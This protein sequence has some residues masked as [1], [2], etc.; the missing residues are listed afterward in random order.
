MT[1]NAS[2]PISLAGTTAGQS[3][4]IEL[5]GSGT[6]QACAGLRFQS[7]GPRHEDAG[8][9]AGGPGPWREGSEADCG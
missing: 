9:G 2:G 3:I 4:Q 8:S 6:T 5:G 7:I 1:L